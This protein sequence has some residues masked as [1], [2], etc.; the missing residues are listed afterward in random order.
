MSNRKAGYIVALLIGAHPRD[1]DT[2]LTQHGRLGRRG[3]M[4][5]S[6]VSPG[7]GHNDEFSAR[8]VP[9]WPTS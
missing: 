4:G 1:T 2:P 6:P 9:R 7:I 3:D 8:P 5:G